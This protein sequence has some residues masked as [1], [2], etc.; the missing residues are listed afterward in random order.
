MSP[1]LTSRVP[2][3]TPPHPPPATAAVLPH[4]PATLQAVL[5]PLPSCPN[6]PSH[7]S[8]PPPAVPFQLSHSSCPTPAVPCPLQPPR[9]STP[10]VPL[11]LSLVPSSHPSCPTPVI[12]WPVPT[13]QEQEGVSF[14]QLEN[15]LSPRRIVGEGDSAP[16]P[17]ARGL[18]ACRDSHTPSTDV[19]GS[20]AIKFKLYLAPQP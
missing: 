1:D 16:L 11:Q 5:R 3:S 4:G 17:T 9:C 6:Q 19:T 2:L 10:A 20:L 12:L 8:C 14:V 7:S 18:H 15:G 13:P